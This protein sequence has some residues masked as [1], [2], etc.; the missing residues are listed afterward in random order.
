MS[1]I[2][3]SLLQNQA[4]IVLTAREFQTRFLRFISLTWL[5]PPMVGFTFLLYI[6]VFS[7][8]QLISMMSTP[9]KPLF[10]VGG[11]LLA[12]LYF[13]RYSKLLS[14]YLVDPSNTNRELS[15][16]AMKSFP[17]HYWSAFV[18]YISLAPAAAIISLEISSS[19]VALPVD[20]F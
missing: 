5:L 8:D 4:G 10:L 17:L 13:R 14:A 12:W 9:L 19:Y 1:I 3:F 16:R 11:F 20:W 6:E 2:K 7:F 15:E 18:G